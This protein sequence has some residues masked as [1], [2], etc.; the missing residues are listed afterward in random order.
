MWLK[1]LHFQPDDMADVLELDM[2]EDLDN[3]SN[4]PV[5]TIEPV[6]LGG[7]ITWSDLLSLNSPVIWLLD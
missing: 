7:D 6:K 5:N 4:A 2:A 1:R 3:K